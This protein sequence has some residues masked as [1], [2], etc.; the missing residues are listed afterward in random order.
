MERM[1]R[2][3][4]HYGYGPED[5][6]RRQRLREILEPEADRFSEAF[7]AHLA[8]DPYT[9]GFFPSPEAEAR[10]K[11][12]SRAWLVALLRD[13][14]DGGYLKRLRRAGKTHVD[15]GLPGHYVA[16]AMSFTRAY[17]EE[18]V[19]EAVAD[20]AEARALTGTLHKL[21]DLSLDAM[22]EAYREE[23][24][25]RV[26]LS[27]RVETGLIRWVERVTYGLNLLL[28]V[29]LVAMTVAITALFVSDVVEV[30]TGRIDVGVVRAL[31]SLLILWMMIELLHA[32]VRYLRGGHF[33]LRVFL[34]LALVAFIRKLFV[35]ALEKTNAV[36]FALLLAAL[37][38]LGG[39]FI[40]IARAERSGSGPG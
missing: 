33:T 36:D 34:E 22:T 38:V 16:A 15:I 14:L 21:L 39:L 24:L 17:L 30:A 11:A 1:T 9:K 27:K 37:A 8:A 7:F 4:E 35:A 6:A 26:F 32:E 31:G 28:V 40:L 3:L 10:R 12:T 2:V 29:G 5:E 20:P 19:W 13:P 18:R 25:R 23:E